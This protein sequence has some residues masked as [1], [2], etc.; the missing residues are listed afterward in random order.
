MQSLK[1]FRT[2]LLIAATIGLVPALPASAQNADAQKVQQLQDAVD[3]LAAQVADLKRQNAEKYADLTNYNTNATK[4]SLAN[5]RPTFTSGDGAFTASLRVLAQGDLAYYGQSSG[6]GGVDLSSGFNFR[7]ARLGLEGKLFSDWSY[8]FTGELGGSGTEGASISQASIQYDG[9]A[10][11]YARIGIFSPS[12]GLE[13]GTPTSDLLFLERAQ[14]TDVYRSTA[15]ADGRAAIQLFNYTNNFYISAAY[16]GGASNDAAVFDEQQAAVG[17][18]AYR[19]YTDADVNF[20]ISATGTHVFKVADATAGGPASTSTFRFRERPELNVDGTRLIDTGAINA[21]SAWTYGFEAAAN[22]RNLYLQGGY[23]GF[24]IDRRAS[25]Q[26][27]PDFDGWYAQASW[28]LTGETRAYA[29]ARGAFQAIRPAAPFSLSN[30]TWG[31]WEVAARYSVED[32]NYNAGNPGTVAAASAVRGGNQKIWTAAL[33]W[34]PNNAVRFQL[35]YQH[36]DVSRLNNAGGNIG[37]K[38]DA[39]SLRA[40]LSL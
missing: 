26:P 36:T 16:T 25:V 10:P 6:L 37:G 9:A 8:N 20:V 27:N 7:R 17:Y 19:V 11:F 28:A 33:N 40:Q 22:Y 30:G 23:F 31:A 2:Q 38:V 15:A 34:Y 32:L 35:N 24:G 29:P 13:D 12:A 18:A 14:P 1:K 39:V 21:D 5:G 3:S 4:I